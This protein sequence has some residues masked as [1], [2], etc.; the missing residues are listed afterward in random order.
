MSRLILA[1]GVLLLGCIASARTQT[2]S[3]APSPPPSASNCKPPEQAG[4]PTQAAPGGEPFKVWVDS[5]A[6]IYYRWGSPHYGKTACG[7][8]MSEPDARTAGARH[9]GWY[10]DYIQKEVQRH[11][12][13]KDIDPNVP[14]GAKVVVGFT[15]SRAGLISDLKIVESSEWPALESSC[16]KAVQDVQAFDPLPAAYK[17]PT[18]TVAYTCTYFQPR[19]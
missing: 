7:H 11:W 10:V 5:T 12:S 3:V 13:T 16:I 4:N 6:K 15:I 18:L 17:K 14:S 2:P 9:E 1:L 8:Y 19:K